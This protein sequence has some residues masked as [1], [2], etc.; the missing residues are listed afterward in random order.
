MS[1]TLNDSPEL[2]FLAK[3]HPAYVPSMTRRLDPNPEASRKS[4]LTRWSNG[5]AAQNYI[6]A[7]QPTSSDDNAGYHSS[8]GHYG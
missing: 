5:E 1:L 8:I 7:L 4:D 3:G 2:A 6:S